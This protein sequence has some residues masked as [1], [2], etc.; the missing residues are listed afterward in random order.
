MEVVKNQGGGNSGEAGWKWIHKGVGISGL[1]KNKIYPATHTSAFPI[2]WLDISGQPLY[3]YN[4]FCNMAAN[5]VIPQVEIFMSELSL[6]GRVAKIEGFQFR[7][8]VDLC[9]S[10]S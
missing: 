2:T 10:C 8:Q 5:K 1:S 3:F 6:R 9:H 4:H 7:R